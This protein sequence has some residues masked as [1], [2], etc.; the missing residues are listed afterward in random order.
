MLFFLLRHYIDQLHTVVIDMEYQGQEPLI[1][2]HLMNILRR[3]DYPVQ[4]QQITFG[5]IGKHSP[6][7]N[8]AIETFR[9]NRAPN[10]ILSV[11][12]VLGQ[13]RRK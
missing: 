13:F 12:D 5:H 7:H 10:L 11:E 9:R 6:A 3:A 1:K 2:D 4:R 8:I